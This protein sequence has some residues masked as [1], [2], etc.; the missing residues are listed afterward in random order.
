MRRAGVGHEELSRIRYGLPRGELSFS[1]TLSESWRRVAPSLYGALRDG[2]AHGYGTQ[3]IIYA[4]RRIMLG[5]SV[6][7]RPTPHRLVVRPLGKGGPD[8]DAVLLSVRQLISDLR[9]EF[10]RYEV[11][12][13][14]DGQ[15]RDAFLDRWKRGR[16]RVVHDPV[17]TRAWRELSSKQRGG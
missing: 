2:L 6:V 12:L 10:D 11:E 7:P 5:I 8:A 1:E 16:E 13:R 3:T 15:L 14:Q 17:E 9:V 4:G